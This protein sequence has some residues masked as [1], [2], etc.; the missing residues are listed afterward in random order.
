MINHL[1]D[2]S[3]E[4]SSQDY[5]N[6]KLYTQHLIHEV[7]QALMGE[8]EKLEGKVPTKRQLTKH[9]VQRFDKK[10]GETHYLWKDILLITIKPNQCDAEGRRG[11]LL[12]IHSIVEPKE[13]V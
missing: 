8:I 10:T 4:P 2:P 3:S 11:T 6:A 13:E 5:T 1:P 9:G 7:E 12:V